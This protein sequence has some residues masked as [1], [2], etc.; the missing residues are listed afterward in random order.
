MTKHLTQKR[1]DFV[2][3]YLGNGRNGLEAHRAAYPD[4]QGKNQTRINAAWKLLRDPRIAALVDDADAKEKAAL[5]E[6]AERHAISKRRL[7]DRLAAIVFAAPVDYLISDGGG[8]P[9]INY[10][11]LAEAQARGLVQVTVW[12]V[13]AGSPDQP[14]EARRIRIKPV[15]RTAAVMKLARLM[16]YLPE[17]RQIRGIDDLTQE[18]IDVLIDGTE[19]PTPDREGAA[20][21]GPQG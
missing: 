6:V 19:E 10:D 21:P 18:E 13:A 1:L 17:Q 9:R 16:G 11:K 2:G 4:W 7:A 15:D 20:E 8:V 14:A 3:A 5:S 12:A